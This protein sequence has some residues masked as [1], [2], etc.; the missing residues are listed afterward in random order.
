MQRKQTDRPGKQTPS[1]QSLDRGL[2]IV[3]AVAKASGKRTLASVAELAKVCAET[4]AHGFATDD[5]EYLEGVRCVAAPIRAE[6]GQIIGAIGISAPL[7]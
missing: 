4:R 6:D 2:T 1:I 7:T 3:E 5:E